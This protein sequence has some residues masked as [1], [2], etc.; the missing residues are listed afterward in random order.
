M[1]EFIITTSVDNEFIITTSDDN[2][3]WKLISGNHWFDGKT[4]VTFT[5]KTFCVIWI[6]YP[7]AYVSMTGSKKT[8]DLLFD[9]KRN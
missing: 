9:R 2:E 8:A 1:N 6:E 4:D 3:V 5:K 7:H